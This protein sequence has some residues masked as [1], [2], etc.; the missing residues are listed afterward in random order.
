MEEGLR[1][2]WEVAEHFGVPQEMVALQPPLVM[3]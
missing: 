3:E 1:E 2:L